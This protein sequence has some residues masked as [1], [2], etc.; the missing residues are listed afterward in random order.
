MMDNLHELSIFKLASRLNQIEVE[1]QQLYIRDM[2]NNRGIDKLSEEYDAIIQELWTRLP[3]LRNDVNLQPK[4]RVKE[5][6]K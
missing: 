6:K 4:R 3:N 5:R 2:K 1:L